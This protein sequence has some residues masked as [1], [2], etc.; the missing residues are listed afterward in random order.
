MKRRFFLKMA[1]IVT[2]TAGTALA[3][4]KK[5][6]DW[7]EFKDKTPKL[8]TYFRIKNKDTGDI[9]IGYI[10]IYPKSKI[11]FFL[12]KVKIDDHNSQSMDRYERKEWVWRYTDEFINDTFSE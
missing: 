4:N 1:S 9:R 11:K 8:H 7:H 3:S 10:K 6:E 5:V 2:A 12:R